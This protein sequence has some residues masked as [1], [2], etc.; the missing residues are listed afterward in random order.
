M[1]MHYSSVVVGSFNDNVMAERAIHALRDAGFAGDEISYSTHRGFFDS[2]KGW[3]KGDEAISPSD[4]AEDLVSMGIPENVAN[5]Y[6]HEYQTNHPLVAVRSPGHERNAMSILR[7]IGGSAYSTSEGTGAADRQGTSQGTD[8]MAGPAAGAAAGTA[9][10]AG[11]PADTMRTQ[12]AETREREGYVRP[13]TQEG[14]ISD[15]GEA[16]IPV[17]EERLGAEKQNVQAGEVRIHKEVVTE[18]KSID[19]PVAHEEVVVERHA[20]TQPGV[21]Q[22]PIGQD[23][24]IR[25]PVSEEQVNVT[26][27][28]VETGDVTIGKRTVQEEKRFTESVRREEPRIESSGD[29]PIRGEN[30]QLRD[31]DRPLRDEDMP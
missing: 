10:M 11:Q 2:L 7:S 3:L 16:H 21:S 14:R 6:A 12:P 30:T 31:E 1:T 17:R 29:V 8:A 9:A 22:T 13:G 4:I 27:T 26:K 15:T 18:Q 25:I 28:P 5:Y 20:A 19:V 24:E 23:E